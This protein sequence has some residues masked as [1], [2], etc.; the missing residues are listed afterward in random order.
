M[1]EV[2]QMRGGTPQERWLRSPVTALASAALARCRRGDARCRLDG[3]CALGTCSMTLD[4]LPAE[5]DAYDGEDREG[6]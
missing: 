2:V 1:G 4:P 6:G 3:F 5:R